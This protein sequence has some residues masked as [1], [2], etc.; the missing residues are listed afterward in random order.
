MKVSRTK[1]VVRYNET[2]KM[3]IVHHSQYVNWFEV[4]RTDWIRKAGI[5]YKQIEENGLMIPVIGIELHYHSPAT[6]DD[7]V[8]VE[9]SLKAYDSIKLSYQYRILREDNGKLLADGTSS[10]CWT[11]SRM[12]PVSLRKKNP[13]LDQFIRKAS[14]LN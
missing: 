12:H 4:G 6:F 5:P 2:D 13:E 8:I 3:G 1:I 14:G 9:T 11:D 10:H 7:A